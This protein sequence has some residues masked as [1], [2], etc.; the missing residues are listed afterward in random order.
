MMCEGRRALRSPNVTNVL[1]SSNRSA[2][3][4]MGRIL[5]DVSLVA[6]SDAPILITGETGTGKDFLAN[7]IHN[8]SPRRDSGND[9]AAVVLAGAFFLL[10]MMILLSPVVGSETGY[11]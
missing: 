1:P 4:Q 8:N 7:Y 2:S 11:L 10:L 6:G 5:E 3:P 9:C